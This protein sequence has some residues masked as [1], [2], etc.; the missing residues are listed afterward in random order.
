MDWINLHTSFLDSP[1]FLGAEPTDRA[2]WL[3]LLRYCVGQ[4]NSGTIAAAEAWGDRKWQQLVRVT[5]KEVRRNCDLWRWIGDDLVVSAYP[6]DKQGEI[7]GK[8]NGGRSGGKAITQAKGDSA[9]A[10]GALGGRPKTQAITQAETETETQAEPKV[11]P[12]EGERKGREGEGESTPDPS[13]QQIDDIMK[14]DQATAQRIASEP[15]VYSW[16]DW[17]REHPR[18]GIAR[19]GE[20]GDMEAWRDLWKIYGRVCFDGMYSYVL[21]YVVDGKKIWYAQAAEWLNKNTKAIP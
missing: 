21:P 17:R 19:T 2:T 7:Q 3:C 12:T 5:S 15:M 10:N 8:R 13:D 20:D 1:D 6:H 14:T 11:N 4:E 16:Q 18:I 9:R